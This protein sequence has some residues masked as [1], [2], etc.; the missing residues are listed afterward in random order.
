M[1]RATFVIL[2]TLSLAATSLVA[3][4]RPAIKVNVP[5]NFMVGAKTLPAGE[6][7]VQADRLQQLVWIRSADFKSNLNLISNSAQNAQMNGVAAL[8][9]HRYGDRYFLSQIWTGSDVGQELLKSRAEKEQIAAVPAH[10]GIVTLA[11]ER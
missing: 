2:A 6:Y 3:Q 11:A 9:F 4:S 8:M 10:Q 7:Q 5:F 1:K